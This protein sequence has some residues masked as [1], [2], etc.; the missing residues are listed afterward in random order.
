[1]YQE[2]WLMPPRAICP[3]V[4]PKPFEKLTW[5]VCPPARLSRPK[6]AWPTPGL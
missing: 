3:S 1:M 4:V 6:L 2:S 5:K